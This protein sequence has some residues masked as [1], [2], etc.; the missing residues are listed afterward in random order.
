MLAFS[1][2]QGLVQACRPQVRAPITQTNDAKTSL[3]TATLA[4]WRGA[5]AAARLESTS[6]NQACVRQSPRSGRA[7][8][9]AH[10]GCQLRESKTQPRDA[11]PLSV[12]D[13]LS[14][15]RLV[16]LSLASR[17]RA[18][19]A[20]PLGLTPRVTHSSCSGGSPESRSIPS[21]MASRLKSR[22]GSLSL[23]SVGRLS[24]GGQWPMCFQPVARLL[25][26]APSERKGCGSTPWLS[27][28]GG[29]T[30]RSGISWQSNSSASAVSCQRRAIA[31]CR[32]D[33]KA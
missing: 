27:P 31:E 8:G 3:S 18:F 14:H 20:Q 15:V 25:W 10:R 12:S 30:N 1:Q 9:L 2:A 17:C 11:H 6:S 32:K 28:V 7:R 29:A 33:G 5:C 19:V 26:C 21:V 16:G 23:L 4:E 13:V 24:Q 22:Q